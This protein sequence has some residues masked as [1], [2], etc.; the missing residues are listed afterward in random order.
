MGTWKRCSLI[1]A[2]LALC[3]CA[4]HPA[5]DP[6]DPLEPV[7]R[8]VYTFN[9]KADHYVLRPAAK[10][11][12]AVMPDWAREGIG[13]FF[14]NLFYP[15]TIVNDFLQAKFKQGAADTG[16]FVVNSIY[17][18][19]GLIDVGNR[20]GLSKHDEDFGQTLGY[21]GVGEGW[22]LMLPFLGPN[23]NRDL[24]GK[25]VDIFTN[26]THYLPGRYDLPQYLTTFVLYNVDRRANLLSTDSLLESQFDQYLF[27]RTAYLQ[28][29]QAM[30]YDGNPPPEDLGLSNF[31]DDTN[32]TNAPTPA[33]AKPAADPK[34]DKP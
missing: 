1:L 13:N 14:S 4:H 34:T 23:D 27:I 5:D 6:A 17:G 25:G 9:S 16:R 3:A 32:A 21:W 30:V 11:Y 12:A 28:H 8:A 7:N 2:V 24:V 10:G 26:P 19:G 18:V 33:A 15:T 20:V 22:F 31:D 29:R